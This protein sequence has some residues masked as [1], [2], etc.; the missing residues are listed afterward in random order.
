M[1]SVH[2]EQMLELLG[3]IDI[4]GGNDNGHAALLLLQIVHELPELAARKRVNACGGFVQNQQIGV[5]HQGAAQ[6]QF[7][8]H[9]ARQFARGAV[10]EGGKVRGIQ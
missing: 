7:L 2:C 8:L 4:G 10:E 9:A 1:P 6:A 3:F 5:V